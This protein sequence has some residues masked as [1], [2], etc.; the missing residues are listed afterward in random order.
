MRFIAEVKE[1]QVKKLASNDKGIRIILQGEDENMLEAGNI[2]GDK[3]VTV[4]IEVN[5]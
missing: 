1:V 4:T 2:P 3:T 5:D